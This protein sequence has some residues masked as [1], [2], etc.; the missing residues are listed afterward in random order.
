MLDF[1]PFVRH[2]NPSKIMKVSVFGSFTLRGICPALFILGSALAH[3]A[4]APAAPV[5]AATPAAS[6]TTTAEPAKATVELPSIIVCGDSTAKNTG[7]GAQGWGTAIEAYFDPAKVKINNV[8]HA[9]TSSLTYYNGDWPKVLPQIKTGDYVLIV[10]GIND[11]G[12]G[13]PAGLDD[14]LHDRTVRGQPGE[15]AHTYGWYM[16]KMA[17]DALAKGAHVY[18]LTV[19][20]RDIWTNPK[21]TFTD[22]KITKQEEGYTTT[23]DKVDQKN[24]GKYPE[25]TKAVGAKLHLPVVDLTNIEALTMEKMGREKVMVNYLDHNHTTPTG[26]EVVAGCVVAGLKAFKNSP[27]TAMLSEKGKMLEPADAK[28]VEENPAPA[29]SDTKAE[30]AP[31]AAKPA[32]SA[33]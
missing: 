24:W 32:S 21:A 13:T 19:T 14:D 2:P 7:R 6:A 8:A 10:F 31:E 16:S 1:P 23:E 26:A 11:G 20:A 17:T 18:F 25:W 5:A 22:A 4:E 9:G 33:K 15:Q 29:K 28:W 30:A 3:A 27:F 12:L